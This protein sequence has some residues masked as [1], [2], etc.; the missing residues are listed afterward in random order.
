MTRE[1]TKGIFLF[2]IVFFLWS[3]ISMHKEEDVLN[4]LFASSFPSS[5]TLRSEARFCSSHLGAAR[6]F[7]FL[8]PYTTFVSRHVSD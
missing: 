8:S 7:G 4:F 3:V 1:S 5:W 2:Q 6:L